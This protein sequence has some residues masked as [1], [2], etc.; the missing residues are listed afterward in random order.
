MSGPF[1]GLKATK[2]NII[3]GRA[4]G[5]VIELEKARERRESVDGEV[6]ASE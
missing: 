3:L 4:T 5:S 6:I 2:G 1:V